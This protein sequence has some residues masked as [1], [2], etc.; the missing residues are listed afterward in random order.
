MRYLRAPA[1][2]CTD[3]L[4]HVRSTCPE[5]CIAELEAGACDDC[6]GS[7]EYLVDGVPRVCICVGEKKSYQRLE[8]EVERLRRER[9]E[10]RAKRKELGDHFVSKNHV[11]LTLG[12]QIRRAALLE[13]ADAAQSGEW[14][15]FADYS[16]P[17]DWAEDNLRRLA[18]QQDHP[19]PEE[20]A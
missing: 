3:H 14:D 20:T 2:F 11:V 19:A 12:P 8:A 5:C 9:D 1:I 13:A 6:D 10:E 16:T 15:D 18:D 4:G 7:G 17:A